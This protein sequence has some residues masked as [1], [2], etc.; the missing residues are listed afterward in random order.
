ICGVAW[1]ASLVPSGL[2]YPPPI[3]TWI[4]PF[5]PDPRYPLQLC[6]PKSRARTHSIHSN[7]EMLARA[8]R[9]DV[10]MH[11]ADAAARGLTDGQRVRVFNGRGATIVPVPVTDRIPPPVVS[12]EQ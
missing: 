3:P 11:P 8:D 6:T 5:E 1:P 12:I 10:W 4:P 9:D 2:A 7:Q